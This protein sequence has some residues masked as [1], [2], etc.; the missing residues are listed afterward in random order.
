M[1]GKL[2]QDAGKVKIE[3]HLACLTFAETRNTLPTHRRAYALARQTAIRSCI[4]SAFQ[5][6]S[7]D[8][9]RLS[10]REAADRRTRKFSRTGIHGGPS[11]NGGADFFVR[12]CKLTT[13]G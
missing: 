11:L 6:S 1:G 13:T 3:S 4:S 2:D 12:N 8:L 10:Q 5:F 7:F 9:I